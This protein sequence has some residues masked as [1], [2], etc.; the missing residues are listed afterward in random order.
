MYIQYPLWAGTALGSRN[1]EVTRIP[2]EN[3]QHAELSRPFVQFILTTILCLVAFLWPSYCKLRLR[4]SGFS[5]S[6]DFSDLIHSLSRGL[7]PR[8]QVTPLLYRST[9]QACN[10]GGMRDIWV[11][12]RRSRLWQNGLSC[13]T[14]EPELY[15]EGSEESVNVIE[16][17]WPDA[18]CFIC[19]TNTCLWTVSHTGLDARDKSVRKETVS[20]PSLSLQ[21]DIWN[22]RTEKLLFS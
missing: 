14:W 9:V 10:V 3:L 6:P 1:T 15:S 8:G 11:P 12:G 2:F 5:S 17:V 16:G 21:P 4:W 20:L 19:L 18:T 13:Q 22:D 7:Q